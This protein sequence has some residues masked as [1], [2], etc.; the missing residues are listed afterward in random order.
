MILKHILKLIFFSSVY[1]VEDNGDFEYLPM[2][3]TDNQMKM[4]DVILNCDMIEAKLAKLKTNKSPGLDQLHPRVLYE[5]RNIVSYPLL[6]FQ[7]SLSS[8]TLPL[9]WK[10]AE[11]RALYKKGSKSDR[12]NYRPVSLTSVCCKLL[13]SFTCLIKNNLICNRQYDFIK[14]RSSSLQL[15][16]MLDR[17][18]DYLECGGQIDVVYTDFEKAFDKVLH[19]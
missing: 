2:R 9:D 7:K 12:G 17:L 15:L 14:G 13:E 16:H 10:L 19:R 3:I 18:T 5:L 11:V 8:G 6:I 4:T 1:T